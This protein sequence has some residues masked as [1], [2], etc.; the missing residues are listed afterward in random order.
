MSMKI[1]ISELRQIIR[2]VVV[3]SFGWPVESTKPVYGIN[4]DN[5]GKPSQHDGKNSALRFP[6]GPNSKQKRS[7]NES[8]SKITARELKEWQSGNW[9]Y[10]HEDSVNTTECSEC[11]GVKTEPGGL[12]PEGMYECD[13]G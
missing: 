2:E 7:V 3:E 11:G 5:R 13:C 4:S 8:F 9:G 10:L 12:M 6:R 1:T